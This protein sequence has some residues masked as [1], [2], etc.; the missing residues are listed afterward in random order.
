MGETGM[1]ERDRRILKDLELFRVMSRDQLIKRHFKQLKR[2]VTVC[3]TVL[4]RLRRDGHIKVD[5]SQ[6]PYRY[7]PSNAN[8]K[9]GSMK[10]PHF[11]SLVDVFIELAE[12]Q[13]TTRFEIEPKLGEKGTIEPDIF[14][15]W[16]G[17]PL[18]IE[19]QRNIYTNT[20]MNQKI[21]RYKDYYYRRSWEQLDWQPK[22]KKYFPYVWIITDHIY[23][24][25]DGLPFK[26]IQAK[27][28]TQFLQV[29]TQKKQGV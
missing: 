17:S 21:Q 26:V 2:S 9:T 7:F 8:F 25:E 14:T 16:Q 29:V 5:T 27:D 4:K 23:T 18:F 1:R 15:I 10:I 12:I 13:E 20:V 24:I 3:N 11:L 28:V 6:F 19:V 22:Q